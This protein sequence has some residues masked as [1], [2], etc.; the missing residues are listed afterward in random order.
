MAIRAFLWIRRKGRRVISYSNLRSSSQIKQ[1][2]GGRLFNWS[3][4]R[5]TSLLSLRL[6]WLFLIRKQ[7]DF[8]KKEDAWINSSI[9]VPPWSKVWP[10]NLATLSLSLI[11]IQRQRIVLIRKCISWKR[12]PPKTKSTTC[13]I[14]AEFKKPRKCLFW[15]L[16]KQM[17][18]SL[19]RKISSF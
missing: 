10:P 17:S 6:R 7:V 19:K 3:C 14:R 2:I 18:I 1:E 8:W 4:M 13:Y 16:T 9:K 11:I 15:K 5:F 12:Y